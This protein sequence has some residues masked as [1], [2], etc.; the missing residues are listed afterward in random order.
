MAICILFGRGPTRN[1][2][3]NELW[4]GTVD[5]LTADELAR[6][7]QLAATWQNWVFNAIFTFL[8]AGLVEETLKYLPIAYVRHRGD[9]AEQRPHRSRAYLDYTL[10]A[11]LGFG[12]VEAIG[13]IYA[14]CADGGET[15]S[16][17]A[18]TVLE[19]VV[20]SLGHLLVTALTALRATRKDFCG[21]QMSWLSVT[22]PAIVFHG[23][24][25][26]VAISASALEG[27]VGWIHP[28]GTWNTT[29]MIGLTTALMAT[30]A[31]KVGREWKALE[32][33]DR[34]S[35]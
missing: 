31:W 27:N 13:F 10:S 19:R 9:S 24:F 16:K 33:R 11:A 28:T 14:A 32:D 18:L 22:G 3:W 8:A 34:R 4:R 20:G 30:S 2:F 15:G 12:V 17:L 23:A 29:A 7:A 5:G 1:A 21:D 26:F 35:D 25:N 6:R